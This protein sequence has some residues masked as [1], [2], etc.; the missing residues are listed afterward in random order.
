MY[1]YHLISI[2]PQNDFC[3]PK[4]SLFVPGADKDMERLTAF[5]NNNRGRLDKIHCTLDSH[6][7]LHIA[8]P[9]FWKDKH[10]NHPAPFTW[11]SVDD[12]ETGAWTSTHPQMRDRALNYVRQ[13]AL[14]TPGHKK[15]YDLVIWPVHCRI[16]SWG[17]SI[18]PEY[19]A[20]LAAWEEQEFDR[21][22]YVAKG[23][24]MFTEHYSAV[25]ADVPDDADPATK[26]NTELIDLLSQPVEAGGPSD[27]FIAGQ[28]LN[29]CVAN[30]IRDIVNAFGTD[31]VKKFILLTDTTSNVPGYEH[32]G[33]SFLTDLKAM[34]MRTALSTD[35]F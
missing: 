19:D 8:H 33:E 25:Q 17:A 24:N 32:L 23:S 7:T 1:R 31:N 13:L 5:V 10:G 26:L 16:G 22:N 6:Q 9:L 35:S 29:F 15:R 2:D 4:G 12:V 3:S 30:T 20:A 21:V 18:V 34:G 11:I 28:A 14:D 27:I